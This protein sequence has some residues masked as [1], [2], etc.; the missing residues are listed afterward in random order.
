MRKILL[1]LLTFSVLLI[2]CSSKK[3][4][5]EGYWMSDDGE[6]ITFLESGEIMIDGITCKYSLDDNKLLLVFLGSNKEFKYEIKQNK[7]Y[8]TDLENNTT[9]CYYKDKNKQKEIKKQVAINKKIDECSD[10]IKDAKNDIQDNKDTIEY[11]KQDNENRKKSCKE[12]IEFGD[13]KEYQ[14]NLRDDFI[15]AN[16]EKIENLKEENKKLEEQINDYQTEIDN[17]KSDK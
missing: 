5:L 8:I 2:G 13:D 11:Y 15:K 4:K 6:T 14:E 1:L 3:E 9:T 17:L 12:A 7:L 10:K 16:N